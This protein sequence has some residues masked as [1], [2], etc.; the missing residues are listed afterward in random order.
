MLGDSSLFPRTLGW[1]RSGKEPPKGQGGLLR[2]QGE[3]PGWRAERGPWGCTCSG[4]GAR[5]AR[6]IWETTG[7]ARK[8]PL[9][10]RVPKRE[11]RPGP[12]GDEG[13]GPHRM[14]TVRPRGD[15]APHR[16]TDSTRGCRGAPSRGLFVSVRL[17]ERHQPGPARPGTEVYRGR[18][19][20]TP[21]GSRRP[22]AGR[23]RSSEGPAAFLSLPLS[24]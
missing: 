4:E 14:R 1:E 23:P 10:R 24:L 16:G 18:R 12:Q 20:R 8:Q 3:A 2:H 19:P 13:R 9:S 21:P 22:Q 17:W 15:G 6:R 7:P 5:Q 11:G